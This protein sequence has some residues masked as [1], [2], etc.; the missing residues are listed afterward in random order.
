MPFKIAARTILQLGAE[1]ISSD[2]IA[3]YELV[4][5]SVD[6]GSPRVEIDIRVRMQRDSYREILKE[7]RMLSPNAQGK[8]LVSIK[9]KILGN[10]DAEDPQIETNLHFCETAFQLLALV[11]SVNSITMTDYGEG[12]TLED[13][14]DVFLTIGTR[15]RQRK[16]SSLTEADKP[17][18]GEK[19]I[20]RL[21]SMRLGDR[22]DVNTSRE[23]EP[24]W[25]VLS[26]DWRIFSHDS[27][28]L[29]GD[30]P[31]EPVRGKRKEDK[32]K[33]GTTLLI[34]A[35]NSE[36]NEDKLKDISVTD[37][38]RL[39][40]PFS[41]ASRFRIILRFNG[42]VVPIASI[43]R[44]LLTSAH[45][46]CT[47]SFIVDRKNRTCQITGHTN[48]NLRGEQ[49]DFQIRKIDLLQLSG[50]QNEDAL[51]DVGPFTF[52]W[53]WFN[54]RILAAVEGIGDRKRVGALVERWGGGLM[55]FRDGFRVNPYGSQ[56]DDWLKLDPSALASQGYKVN[57]RQIIGKI[58]ISGTRNPALVDQTNREGLRDCPEKESLVEI[59]NYLLSNEFRGFL[60][61][62][63]DAIREREQL[64]FTILEERLSLQEDAID[65]ALVKLLRKYPNEKSLVLPIRQGVT[66]IREVMVQA[67]EIATTYENRQA[68]LF[69]LAGVGLITEIVAHE[70]NRATIHT[71]N[72]VRTLRL[73]KG[74]AQQAAL[75]T[76]EQQLKTLQKRLR[77]IDP[78]STSGR[79][80]K[81]HFDLVEWINSIL[82]S[83]EEQFRRHA[84]TVLVKVKP[85]NAVINTY[86]VKGMYV[87][88]LENLI[89]NSVYWLAAYKRLNKGFESKIN[90]VIDA[91]AR[92]LSFTDN[93]PG[94]EP[95]RAEDIFQPFV[96]TKPPRQGKG[97]GLYVSREIARYNGATLDLLDEQ[98]VRPDA[99]N[100]FVLTITEV[101]NNGVA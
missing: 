85:T 63:D 32:A 16:R 82:E 93:G 49:R 99:L 83:H 76:L 78:I 5:N 62:V 33:H 41:P 22:L 45:A 8:A 86:G 53:Y 26:L 92:T 37:F 46:T 64:D 31:I 9:K 38:S 65:R 72:L 14:S 88:V 18:L 27:D 10:L 57:R 94:I 79:Q 80:H 60:T 101:E 73:S 91:K 96:T 87:Q 54:R 70:L 40:D 58:D 6:A 74:Q 20:G 52:E 68:Q 17:P 75:V 15:S 61:R 7:I 48:Y 50:V 67:K 36:W 13:L 34:S 19:G 89:S 23:G 84:I 81:E 71:L 100:T 21:S 55:L 90:I 3:F 66:K 11:E 35:L 98:T 42:A 97:L 56:A 28:A 4:K 30:V 29:L 77:T 44:D 59:M 47:G 95:H 69:N 51:L 2:G 12:M 24:Y 25:N 1:L 43:S 39:T